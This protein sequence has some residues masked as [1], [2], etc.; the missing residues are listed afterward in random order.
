MSDSVLQ[1]LQQ[2]V[3]DVI[4]PDVRELEVR[5]S[6]LEKQVESL[7]NHIDVPVQRRGSEDG[8]PV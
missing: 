2:V 6:S 3:L 8:C 5:M 4:A 7:E 1:T